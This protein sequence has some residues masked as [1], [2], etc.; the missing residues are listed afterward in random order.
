[1]PEEINLHQLFTKN[2]QPFIPHTQPEE[3]Q[4][5]PEDQKN[6]HIRRLEDK[7]QRERESNIQ[8][9]A[10]IEALAEA[11]KMRQQPDTVSWEE[12]ARRIY[13]NDKPENAAASDLLVESI[14]EAAESARIQALEEARKEIRQ[15]QE[16]ERRE[17][18]TVQNYI[19]NIEDRFG[20]DFTSTAQNR[21][22]QQEFREFWYRLSPKDDKGDI[23]AYA[24]PYE[25][26]ELFN[27]RQGSPAKDFASRGMTRTRPV[28]APVQDDATTTFLKENGIIDP[29]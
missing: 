13:G 29:F 8:M 27:A 5:L 14:R 22:R 20:V 24:D 28:E 1:M 2:E 12:K 10:R 6:R 4:E 16:D 17:S 26:F 15:R 23:V 25:T 18:E 19:E 3:P 7:L 21:E 9:S 11:Q